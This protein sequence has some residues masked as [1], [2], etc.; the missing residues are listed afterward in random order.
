MLLQFVNIEPD[1]IFVSPA[2]AL[3][4]RCAMAGLTVVHS[5][6]IFAS[7]DLFRSILTHDCL[8]Q[9]ASSRN[10]KFTLYASAIRNAMDK[11][12]LQI[13][14][15]L[16]NGLVGDFPEDAASTV[17]SIF[18][19]LVFNWSNQILIWLPPVLEQLPVTNIPNDAKT[20]F[21]QEVTA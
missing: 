17:V 18:R 5:D 13:A 2:F 4:F 14:G 8:D 20:Q 7:L 6:I 16:L 19:S 1:V 11:E 3:S 12:G 9:G 15:C 10:S 21:L